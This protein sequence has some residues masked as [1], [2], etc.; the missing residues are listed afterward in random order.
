M[1]G[2]YFPPD[3]KDKT[4]TEKILHIISIVFA[5]LIAISIIVSLITK[6]NLHYLYYSFICLFL[7]FQGIEYWKYNKPIAIV[8]F[9]SSIIFLVAEIIVIIK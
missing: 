3:W 2:N 7:I 9:I 5:C 1:E 8:E 4:K 6:H